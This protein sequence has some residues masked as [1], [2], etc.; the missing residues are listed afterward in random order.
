MCLM[1]SD[2]MFNVLI[3][4]PPGRIELPD[5]IRLVCFRCAPTGS[6]PMTLLRKKERAREVTR[7][8]FISH[9]VSLVRNR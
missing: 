5:R 4:S 7:G 6:A 9:T 8:H 3:S 2:G 1:L